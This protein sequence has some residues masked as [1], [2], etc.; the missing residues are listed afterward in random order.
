M[1]SR[2]R[3]TQT[4]ADKKQYNDSAFSQSSMLRRASRVGHVSPYVLLVDLSLKS[5]RSTGRKLKAWDR[6]SFPS[7]RKASLLA[8]L[9]EG[10]LHIDFKRLSFP[11]CLSVLICVDLCP[12][13]LRFSASLR[14]TVFSCFPPI[15]CPVEC[16]CFWYS[17][18][19]FS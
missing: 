17:T 8:W 7:A 1:K 6:W 4:S 19:A 16:R 14:E 18:G 10:K 12:I 13:S 2:H 3:L 11:L 9:A 5:G 15:A